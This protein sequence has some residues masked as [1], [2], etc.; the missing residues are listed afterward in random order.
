VRQYEFACVALQSPPL[1]VD[2]PAAV[3]FARFDADHP[4]ASDASDIARLPDSPSLAS[5][6]PQTGAPPPVI[7]LPRRPFEI[8]PLTARELDE[9]FGP[10]RNRERT[11]DGELLSFFHGNRRHVVLP[12]KERRLLRR[13]GQV[14]R[15]G[16]SL[17]PDQATLSATVFADGVFASQV[18]VGNTSFNRFLSVARDPLGLIRSSGLR[19]AVD[20][21]DGWQWLA[22]PSAFEMGLGDCRWLYRHADGGI[23]VR[24]A[25]DASAPLMRYEVRQTGRCL[26]LQVTAELSLG[27][28]EYDQGGTV[29]IDDAAGVAIVHPDPNSLLGQTHPRAQFALAVDE[30]QAIQLGGD[31]LQS[32]GDPSR[33]LPCLS[34]RLPAR[35]SNVFCITG[36]M[37][38]GLTPQSIRRQCRQHTCL[39]MITETEDNWRELGTEAQLSTGNDVGRVLSDIRAWFIHDATIHLSAPR[40]L[41]QYNGGAWGTRDVAQ[42]PVELLLATGRYATCRKLLLRLYANQHPDGHWPQWF[43]LPPY[44]QIRTDEAHGDVVIWPLKALCDYV[45]TTGD[46]AILDDTLQV[47]APDGPATLRDRVNQQLHYIRRQFVAGT[48][49]IA[50]GEGDWNDSL[51]PADASLR[52]RMVSVWTAE[53]LYEV[54]G[55]WRDV[56]RHQSS[57]AARDIDSLMTSVAADIRRHLM[58]DGVLGGFAVHRGDARFDLRMHPRDDA[59]GVRYRLLSMNRGILSGLLTPAEAER[60]AELIERH[61]LCRDGA[62]L[63]DTPPP[64]R[65]GIESFFRR[66]ESASCFSREIG[67][68]YTHAHLRYAEAMARLGR[69]DA[70]LLALRQACP[71]ALQAVVPNA[72]L[73]QANA[74]FSSSDADFATRYEATERFDLLRLGGVTVHGGWRVYSSGGGIF[75]GLLTRCLLGLRTDYGRL[76]IDPVLPACLD[77]LEYRGPMLG[78]D[79][80]VRYHVQ[81]RSHTPWRIQAD[82]Q[83]LPF[84]LDTSNPYRDGGAIV[85]PDIVDDV[86]HNHKLID[87]WL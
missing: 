26:P 53:L 78:Q 44:G 7:N 58:A 76:V 66:A 41:E 51:Q 83:D 27:T 43:M 14:Y 40:G 73:R 37:G 13:S 74:Y 69:A 79:I 38:G 54:L 64:Y 86:M 57:P 30:P 10:R 35:D 28:N 29:D 25:F 22:V 11:S 33:N 39:Q 50:Y 84:T 24:C 48:S 62:R 4:A 31:E 77:G 59:S 75:V 85:E 61:L 15:S 45:R 67:L 87:I 63:M 68:M 46:T 72:A 56:L 32:P 81:R 55:Q 36:N 2:A 49:L 80:H 6:P 12:G 19:L 16:R 1:T 47:A 18:A 34:T 60:H 8:Q 5:P 70:L 21:G 65:G 17:L 82:G 71:I 3:F 23:E 52:D 9:H 20:A 42:G